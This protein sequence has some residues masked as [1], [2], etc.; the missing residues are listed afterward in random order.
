MA[1]DPQNPWSG[2]DTQTLHD[3]KEWRLRLSG[4][5]AYVNVP[6]KKEIDESN[7]SPATHILT[8]TFTEN[9]TTETGIIIEKGTVW[10]R[11]VTAKTPGAR[12]FRSSETLNTASFS[13]AVALAKLGIKLPAT[14][15]LDFEVKRVE[16]E[17]EATYAISF[18]DIMSKPLAVNEVALAAAKDA[19]RKKARSKKRAP[20][21]TTSA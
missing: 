3:L 11:S 15:G 10:I 13:F 4:T 2:W 8:R 19:R 1:N 20:G 21:D 18:A 9:V 16:G 6:L 5:D 14:R 12:P 7:G 17:A